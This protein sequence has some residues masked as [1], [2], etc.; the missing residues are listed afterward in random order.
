MKMATSRMPVLV[1]AI[2]VLSPSLELLTEHYTTQAAPLVQAA[3]GVLG[4]PQAPRRDTLG[5]PGTAIVRG[6]V[7][8]AD[9]G[10]PLRKAQVRVTSA[11]LRESWLAT[12]DARGEYEVKELRAGRY[13]L[14]ASKG[15]YVALQYGQTRPFE[16]GRP[17]EILDGQILEK[18]DFSLP[19]GG[20][21]TGRVLD[22]FGEPVTDVLVTTMRSQDV[23]GQ[24]RIVPA[25]RTSTTNDIGEFRLFALPPSDYYISATLRNSAATTSTGEDRSGYAPTYFPGTA[26]IGEAER[27][28]VGLAQTVS[29]I[30]IP[31]LPIRTARLSGRAIDSDGR[32]I[33]GSVGVFC[34]T[35][36]ITPF[37]V[38]TVRTGVD[39]SFTVS[40]LAPGSYKLMADVPQISGEMATL[41]VNIT[42]TDVTD[43]S[44]VGVKPVTAR[45]R[46]V[47]QGSTLK[48]PPPAALRVTV[49]P[50]PV[51]GVVTTFTFG[52]P[53]PP[54]IVKDDYTFET[55]VP[56]GQRQ[57]TVTAPEGWKRKALR[58]RG[59][60]VTDEGIEFKPDE[61]VDD[62]EIE[63]TDR[64]T[65][66]TGSVTNARGEALKDYSVVVF[67]QDRLRW[68]TGSRYIQKG[69]PDQ[70]GRFKLSVPPGDYYVVA[71]DYL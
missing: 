66:V 25:G 40:G 39:G 23:G 22:E 9:T 43:V 18:I 68:I 62:V 28:T 13:S 4:P 59:T 56:P 61:D 34:I 42:G 5:K 63:L 3:P 20:V 30:V 37:T 36:G 27:V 2:L 64:V 65:A 17:V 12:T 14:S 11:D 6:H 52:P 46:I 55:T 10:Q 29:E 8:A 19:R 35:A 70:D 38:G 26:N 21:I 48:V 7:L 49:F 67:P 31:L 71:L 47:F 51:N 24:R 32:P 57:M 1:V 54:T 15:S 69:R 45:G 53:P 50:A 58:L 16:S 44:L 41:D 60:D 33:V